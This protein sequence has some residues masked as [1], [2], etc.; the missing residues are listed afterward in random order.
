[1]IDTSKTKS[2]E[3]DAISYG[4]GSGQEKTTTNNYVSNSS[5]IK[6]SLKQE[7]QQLNVK[8][9]YINHKKE[10]ID[11]RTQQ[12]NR[13]PQLVCPFCDQ[14]LDNSHNKWAHTVPCKQNLSNSVH[15]RE[16]MCTICQKK[17]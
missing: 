2:E 6:D 13:V 15:K 14:Q 17:N 10:T 12:G 7:S 8:I 4:K 1:M 5:L 3:S 9:T 11:T 16:F